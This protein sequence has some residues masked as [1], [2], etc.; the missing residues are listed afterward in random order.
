M[1]IHSFIRSFALV[2][3]GGGVTEI[4]GKWAGNIYSRNKAGAYVKK[5]TVPTNPQTERQLEVRSLF[6]AVSVAWSSLTQLQRDS[7]DAAAAGIPFENSVG[8]E[9]FLSGFGLF[10]KSSNVMH[11]ISEDIWGDCPGDFRIPDAIGG[12][13]IASS[14][15]IPDIILSA[16][17]ANVPAD[18]TYTID[19]APQSNEGVV[20]N[21]SVFKR[22][23]F[24]PTLGM[25]DTGN[26][27][28]VYSAV[29]GDIQ[30]GQRIEFRFAP[31][32]TTNGMLGP[33]VKAA[34]IVV[35]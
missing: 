23:H 7:W 31:V 15:G 4:R 20:N 3:F 1:I 12:T 14:K 5:Y 2:Q 25:W 17:D 13:S 10:C 28:D 27:Y 9:Y 19:A 33:Y 30:I 8:I 34:T 22:I 16:D 26:M 21:N 29:F 32:D 18:R 35:A 24:T 6:S 11:M